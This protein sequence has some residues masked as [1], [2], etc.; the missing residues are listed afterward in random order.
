MEKANPNDVLRRIAIWSL[1]AIALLPNVFALL[2]GRAN[3]DLVDDAFWDLFVWGGFPI[4]GAI[5][6]NSQARNRIGW[7]M[8]AFGVLWTVR[9][10]FDVDLAAHSPAWVEAL[11]AGLVPVVYG[12]LV[13]LPLV[14]PTGRFDS[15]PGRVLGWFLLVPLTIN[16][17]AQWVHPGPLT[18]TGRPNPLGVPALAPV[19]GFVVEWGFFVVPL[20]LLAALIDVGIRW[21]RAVGAERAQ[22]RWFAFGLI[23]TTLVLVVAYVFGGN[24][25]SPLLAVELTALNAIPVTIGIAI[26]RHGLY[27]IGRVLSRT[28]A[29]VLVTSAA[30][31]VYAAIVLTAS[32]FVP[33][34]SPILIAGAT[35]AAAAVFLPLLRLIQHRLDRAFDRERYDAERVVEEFGDRLRNA[36]DPA[37]VTPD[38]VDAIERALQPS[39]LGV[40][41]RRLGPTP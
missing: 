18:D 15:R 28:V 36:V 6:L 29:Y 24:D 33:G 34:N 14:F 22:M 30:V 11:M 40:A 13:L 37:T 3:P 17:L 5:I 41:T 32:L 19:T 23:I 7:V 20:I 38:L 25:L 1:L 26:T 2:F 8:L 10:T 27:A 31:G 35:L 39:I 9:D 21:H 12:L 16:V 4:V